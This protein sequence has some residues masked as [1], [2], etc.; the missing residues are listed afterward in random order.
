MKIIVKQAQ[1]DN[2][3]ADQSDSFGAKELTLIQAFKEKPELPM[4][5]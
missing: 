2:R 5:F 4:L 1:S 3:R